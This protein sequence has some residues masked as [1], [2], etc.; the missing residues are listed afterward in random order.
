MMHKNLIMDQ[1]YLLDS[2]GADLDISA[3]ARDLV[4]VYSGGTIL[5]GV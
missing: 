3:G 5:D 4:R 1:W 2:S